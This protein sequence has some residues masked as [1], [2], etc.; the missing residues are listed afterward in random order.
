MA[1]P[2]PSACLPPLA[3]YPGA[4]PPPHPPGA[5]PPRRARGPREPPRAPGPR[6]PDGPGP[7]HTPALGGGRPLLAAPLGA[8]LAPDRPRPRPRR[9][10]WGGQGEPVTGRRLARPTPLAPCAGPAPQR[11]EA[12]VGRGPRARGG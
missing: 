6:R 3:P 9:T 8:G 1:R 11:A 4:P 2:A 7:P 10:A 5:R 12:R